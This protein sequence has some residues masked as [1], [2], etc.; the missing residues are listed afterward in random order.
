MTNPQESPLDR[1]WQEYSSIFRE[2]DDLTLAR[3]LSQTL[4]QLEGRALR[5]SH[6]LVGA[7]RL[8][9]QVAHDRQI[10]LKRLVTLPASFTEADC[11]RAPLLPIFTR[12]VVE[13]GLG[14]PHCTGT[15][16]QFSDIPPVLQERMKKWGEEYSP[17]HAVA[18]WED[19]QRRAA[20]DYD[21]AFEKA[22]EDAEKLLAYA[23][24]ELVPSLTEIYPAVIWEDHDEC[25]EVRPE[26]VEV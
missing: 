3:W 6:P 11:C 7:Y 16:V 19:K 21:Q 12:D 13:T 20:G 17:V 18:H 9:A 22:A 14:C 2:F 24:R 4:S 26:D 23:G 15:A 5:M 10:W 8:A 1:L 25:L